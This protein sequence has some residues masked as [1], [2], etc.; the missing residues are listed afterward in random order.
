MK[1]FGFVAFAAV[2]AF[3]ADASTDWTVQKVANRLDDGTWSIGCIALMGEAYPL[4]SGFP[5]M[6]LV[7][8]NTTALNRSLR[9]D[10]DHWQPVV[11]IAVDV[12]GGPSRE[13]HTANP[14][15]T[16][17]CEGPAAG[18]ACVSSTSEYRFRYWLNDDTRASDAW[19]G[20]WELD[21]R[22][23]DGNFDYDRSYALTRW[24]DYP[25]DLFA[26]DGETTLRLAFGG[27]TRGQNLSLFRR[28]RVRVSFDYGA[29]ALNDLN[30][31]IDDHRN[32]GRLSLPATTSIGPSS[33][34][35]E[36]PVPGL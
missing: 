25:S 9:G 30:R 29:E 2:C 33:V 5:T 32:G 34:L 6:Y 28:T 7:A 24:Y 27:L 11:N 21:I 36:L 35:S 31:C 23:D 10:E 17:A 15:S 19:A 16:F 14:L 1:N 4:Q 20:S 13:D 26:T 12:T 3:V 22:D 18:V 8:N